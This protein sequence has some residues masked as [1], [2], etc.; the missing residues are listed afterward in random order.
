MKSTELQDICNKLNEYLCSVGAKL[1]YTQSLNPYKQQDFHKFYPHSCKNSV[2][3]CPVL[4]S[5]IAKK[6]LEFS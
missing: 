4:G 1:I 6:Y 5:E 2:L 3:Y